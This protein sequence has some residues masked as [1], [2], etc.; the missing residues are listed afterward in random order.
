[1]GPILQQLGL[2]H[3]FFIQFAIFFF[4]FLVIPNLFFKPFQALIERRH[5]RTVADKEKAQQL[6]VQADQ[7]FDEYKTKLAQERVRARAEY[8][9]VIAQVKAE[10]ASI[11]SEA[12]AEAKKITQAAADNIQEQ[13]VQ[14]RRALEAD[15]ESMALQISDTLLKRQG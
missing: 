1:M 13:S 2:D 10:E 4:V 3:T 11:L 5:D 9:K 15:V 7:K 12:R 14:L 6:V 8:E